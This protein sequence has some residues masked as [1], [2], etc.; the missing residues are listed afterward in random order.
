ML[1]AGGWFAGLAFHPLPDL[2]GPAAIHDDEM[3]MDRFRKFI[4]DFSASLVI[5]KMKIRR[6]G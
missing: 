1:A 2:D 3:F 6:K 4:L 5:R